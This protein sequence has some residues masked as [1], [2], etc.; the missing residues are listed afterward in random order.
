MCTFAE[1]HLGCS[2][3]E[4]AIGLD[5]PYHIANRALGA[6]RKE[7]RERLRMSRMN[8]T[9]TRDVCKADKDGFG[10]A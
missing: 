3:K 4:I 7:W 2:A 9:E 5:L 6:I 8:R 10:N 1:D